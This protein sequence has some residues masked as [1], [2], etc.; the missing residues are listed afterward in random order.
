V[1]GGKS[2]GYQ[3][4]KFETVNAAL[5]PQIPEIDNTVGLHMFQLDKKHNLW[6]HDGGEQGVAT[7]MAFDP[8]T[9]VGAIIFANQGDA[10]LEELLAQAY[11][12]GLKL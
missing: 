4:L 8:A 12:F 5:N 7:I 9:Q 2:N 10:E 1:Q 3:L 6:G 11:Q